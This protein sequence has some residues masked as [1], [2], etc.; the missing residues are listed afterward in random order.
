[1]VLAEALELDRI[2]ATAFFDDLPID[3]VI[4]VGNKKWRGNSELENMTPLNTLFLRLYVYCI[5]A[6]Y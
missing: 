2:I 1:M 4:K 5:D 6:F 3:P